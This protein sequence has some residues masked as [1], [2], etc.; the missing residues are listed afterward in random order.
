MQRY[1]VSADFV[2]GD[3]WSSPCLSYDDYA[4]CHMQTRKQS[5]VRRLPTPKW[6]FNFSMQRELLVA[7]LEKRAYMNGSP[8]PQSKSLTLHQRLAAAQAVLVRRRPMFV[9]RITEL[10]AEYVA[11]KNARRPAGVL[12]KREIQIE[13]LDT[14]LRMESKD[15]GAGMIARIIHLYYSVGFDSVGTAQEMGIKP[16]H[17]RKILFE[18]NATAKGLGWIDEDIEAA[19]ANRTNRHRNPAPRQP[20]PTPAPRR[21]RNKLAARQDEIVALY[22]AGCGLSEIARKIG[23][24]ER[25]DRCGMRIGCIRTVLKRAGVYR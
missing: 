18:L 14:R 1:P 23:T 10:C 8:P 24:G 25:P 4:R 2:G 21:P 16:P 12:R 20:R 11:M 5:G 9:E 13:L 6:A 19:R 3:E 22:N 15:G 7:Y 17:V